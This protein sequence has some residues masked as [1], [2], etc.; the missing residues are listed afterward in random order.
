LESAQAKERSNIISRIRIEYEAAVK[1]ENQLKREFEIQSRVLTNQADDL[2][3]YNIRQRDVETNKK[4]YESTL[5]QG[6]QASLATAMRNSNA[7]VVDA[8]IATDSPSTPNLPLNLALGM[9]AGLLFGSVFAIARSHSDTSI[10]APGVLEAHL[11][12]R[13]LGIIPVASVDSAIRA[14]PG[15]TDSTNGNGNRSKAVG[16]KTSKDCLELVTWSRKTSVISE[17]F[18]S[19]MTSILF[20]GEN[21]DRPKV[22]VITSPSPQDGKSTVVS[23]LAIAL[24]EVNHRVLLIDADMR[25]PRLHTI[26]D[27]P[28]TFG[29]S[30]VLHDRRPIE[31]YDEESLV[32]KTHIPDLYV[33]PAGPARTNLTRLLYSNTMTDL[34]TRM[35]GSFDTIL[36]DS[37]PVLSVPDARFVARSADAIVL[38]VRARQTHQEAAYAAAKCFEEDG[39]QILGTILNDWDPKLSPYG[40]GYVPYGAYHHIV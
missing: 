37:A 29:L 32:R 38:V 35:R 1:R 17:A 11:N 21:G 14:L 28:N 23:N 4:L 40:Q 36:I 18:R 7:R 2:I 34:I 26:F 19:T 39:R 27:V 10:K 15:A 33:L 20:S 12:L 8:A 25:R 9:F 24:A 6:K 22:L 16:E 13:E 30:D 5:Q 31:E 3:E